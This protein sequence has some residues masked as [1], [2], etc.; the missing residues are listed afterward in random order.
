MYE[1]ISVLQIY[2][3]PYAKFMPLYIIAISISLVLSLIVLNSRIHKL[4]VKVLLFLLV[5]IVIIFNAFP[6]F[7]GNV[8]YIKRWNQGPAGTIVVIPEYWQK[9]KAFFEGLDEETRTLIVPYNEYVSLNNWP[10]GVNV[11][12]NIADYIVSA[13]FVKGW[14]PDNSRVGKIFESIYFS[15]GFESD[16]KKLLGFLNIR[17]VLQENDLEWRYHNRMLSPSKTADFLEKSGLTPVETFGLFDETYLKSLANT[18]PNGP[19]RSQFYIDLLDRPALVVYEVPKEYYLPHFY[20]PTQTIYTVGAASDLLSALSVSDAPLLSQYFIVQPGTVDKTKSIA[21]DY[22][23]QDSSKVIII[24]KKRVSFPYSFYLSEWD[25]STPWPQASYNPSG[26]IYPFV[27]VKELLELNGEKEVRKRVSK[28]SWFGAKRI[29]EIKSFKVRGSRREALVD[30][31]IKLNN[32]LIALSKVFFKKSS[33]SIVSDAWY[34]TLLASYLYFEKGLS[35]LED[36]NLSDT[37]L[38]KV[39]LV[40]DNYT[41]LFEYLAGNYAKS[42]YIYDFDIAE[43]GTYDL[44]VN[45]AGSKWEKIDSIQVENDLSVNMQSIIDDKI[46]PI[47]KVDNFTHS[48]ISQ[49]ITIKDWKPGKKYKI[50]F[51][52]KIRSDELLVYGLEDL[53]DYSLGS[54][55][56]SINWDLIKSRNFPI[57]RKQQFKDKLRTSRICVDK[58]DDCYTKYERV[59][60]ASDNSHG[61]YLYLQTPLESPDGS[62]TEVRHLK[63][64]EYTEPVF[65]LKKQIN[66][67]ARIVPSISF[68]KINPTRYEIDIKGATD[69]FTLV[70]NEKFNENWK[71]YLKDT[72][73]IDNEN[74][75]V[76][77]LRSFL[78]IFES[79]TSAA[80]TPISYFDGA[81]INAG[82]SSIFEPKLA[83]GDKTISAL[84]TTHFRSNGF[85][86]A[87]LIQPKD[88][89]GKTDYTLVVKFSLQ[90]KFYALFLLSAAIFL[91]CTMYLFGYLCFVFVGKFRKAYVHN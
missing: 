8:F 43:P 85:A 63:I 50:T 18:E 90:R 78:S 75:L 88:L 13:K 68:S 3:E 66:Q 15:N 76:M 83:L 27:K 10:Y 35:V 62:S 19:L 67:E 12:G 87:W 69:P 51:E 7:T 11:V 82:S 40:R 17:Y 91:I 61:G 32:D 31:F 86:N 16:V 14:N 54:T 29:E 79:T 21:N 60:K 34:N 65:A 36:T 49:L 89:D 47:L 26:P 6:I 38:S 28:Y 1:K 56:H 5:N 59:V 45:I 71:L 44:M 81:I 24:G 30:D 23:R 52:Y 70:F 74:P 20:V 33:D 77:S 48:D 53:F 42:A 57:V 58:N 2:R 37:T 25:N 39:S 55:L 4:W 64:T 9:A 46:K 73:K 41:D 84:T 72:T 22:I 80:T